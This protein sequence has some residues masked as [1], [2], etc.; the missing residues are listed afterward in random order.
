MANNL[1][2]PSTDKNTD[3]KLVSSTLTGIFTIDTVKTAQY[4]LKV[5]ANKK[6]SQLTVNIPYQQDTNKINEEVHFKNF[7]ENW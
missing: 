3:L 4:S 7:L 6:Q 2:L 1:T 5:E